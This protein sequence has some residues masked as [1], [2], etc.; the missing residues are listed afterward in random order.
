MVHLSIWSLLAILTAWQSRSFHLPPK[1]GLLLAPTSITS[2]YS[3]RSFG[4]GNLLVAR[5]REQPLASCC[6]PIG[7]QKPDKATKAPTP[8]KRI[9]QRS[10]IWYNKLSYFSA[11]RFL[12]Y[13][14]AH[15][16]PYCSDSLL[17][18]DPL[19]HHTYGNPEIK[20]VPDP[21][22]LAPSNNRGIIPRL[23]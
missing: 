4:N 12:H 9:S 22:T 3:P 13:T 17:D 2:P 18:Y 6:N 11:W 14:E 1:S 5:Y 21:T 20:L 19:C 15:Y 23:V 8:T 7:A 10:E 16:W